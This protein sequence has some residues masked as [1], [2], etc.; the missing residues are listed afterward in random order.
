MRQEEHNS[1]DSQPCL[2]CSWRLG[3]GGLADARFP[4]FFNECS[5]CGL[6]STYSRSERVVVNLQTKKGDMSDSGRHGT[7]KCSWNL[8]FYLSSCCVQDG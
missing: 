1:E 7:L 2:F 3:I 4:E 6:L 8:N 5:V